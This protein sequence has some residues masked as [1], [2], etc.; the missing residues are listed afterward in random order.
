MIDLLRKYTP[1]MMMR[2]S[3]AWIVRS[4]LAKLL[5]CRTA[6]LRGHVYRCGDCGSEVNV[7]NSCGDRNCPQCGGARRTNWLAKTTELILPN[8]HYFQVVFT[9][10][11]RLSGL[12]LG[13]RRV[14]YSLL[15]RAAWQ[16]LDDVLR[17]DVEVDCEPFQPAAQ[18]VLHTW[19]QQLEHHPHIHAIVPGGGPSLDGD[20]WITS[21]HPT[22]RRRKKPFLVDNVKLGRAFRGHFLRGLRRLLG[23]GELQVEENW[24]FL[25]APAAQEQ[26]LGELEAIDWNVFVE[27]PPRVESRPE[28]V[29]KYLTR[30]LT[31]GPISDARILCD[32]GDAQ[33]GRVT[34]WAR[35]KKRRGGKQRLVPHE[36]SGCEFVR[37]WSL[38]ILPKGFT[39][40][41]SYG[42]F[43]PAKRKDYLARCRSLLPPV[44][45]NHGGLQ[46]VPADKSA[47]DSGLACPHCQAEMS[48]LVAED[49]PSWKQIF[50]RDIHGEKELYS[51]LFHL[52]SAPNFYTAGYD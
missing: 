18:M 14:L 5:L 28:H 44:E 13:N 33:H 45:D 1:T 26:W 34:F 16:A 9:V 20:R 41:R 48:C 37:R 47:D 38:H 27:G 25:K 11:D 50:D 6:V 3:V 35:E 39:R 21:Q 24:S 46:D 42:G 19:N 17:H 7:Y 40:T 23:K 2:H 15:F 8:M 32:E 22:Q 12:M 29:L 4:V 36:L 43:H 51:P 30:Y 10:P 52:P 49:R 31:G